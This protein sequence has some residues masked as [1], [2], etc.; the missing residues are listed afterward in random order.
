M[1]AI[2]MGTIGFAIDRR[3]WVPAREVDVSGL[4]GQGKSQSVNSAVARSVAPIPNSWT[5]LLIP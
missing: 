1:M 3:P 5:H 4:G 2:E